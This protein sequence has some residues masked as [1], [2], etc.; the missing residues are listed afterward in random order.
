MQTLIYK[1][2][3]I[4]TYILTNECRVCFL[5]GSTLLVCSSLRGAKMVITK[6]I[7][8]CKAKESTQ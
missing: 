8:Q 2:F 4:H 6:F 7:N 1:G 5:T 3:Y